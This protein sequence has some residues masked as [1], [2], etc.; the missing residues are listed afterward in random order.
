MFRYC[1]PKFYFDEKLIYFFPHIVLTIYLTP[2]DR[3]IY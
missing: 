1:D 2:K 3:E